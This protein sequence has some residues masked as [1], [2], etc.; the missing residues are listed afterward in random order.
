MLNISKGGKESKV[1]KKALIP[2]GTKAYF[3]GCLSPATLSFLFVFSSC[4]ASAF[5]FYRLFSP[6]LHCLGIRKRRLDNMYS[7]MERN[8][9]NS[10]LWEY[11]S[12]VGSHL[13]STSLYSTWQA[14]WFNISPNCQI[15]QMRKLWI[16]KGL[17]CEQK[18]LAP[19]RSK[20]VRWKHHIKA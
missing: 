7:P 14:L 12:V 13:P 3:E 2:E 10:V 18:R 6:P 1:N 16:K 5:I 9:I 15:N 17:I 11:F 19:R 8:T 20:M 4:F